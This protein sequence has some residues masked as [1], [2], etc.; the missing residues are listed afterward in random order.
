MDKFEYCMLRSGAGYME[1]G[2]FLILPNG[3]Q[4][5]LHGKKEIFADGK[6]C[7]ELNHLGSDGWEVC[8]ATAFVK[9]GDTYQTWTLKRRIVEQ[10]SPSKE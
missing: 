1:N 3:T 2:I 9:G 5:K 6:I 10:Q 7:L 8:S 4:D